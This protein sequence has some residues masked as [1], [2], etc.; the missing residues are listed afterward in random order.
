MDNKTD[1]LLSSLPVIS[2]GLAVVG[3]ISSETSFI[4]SG[5][6]AIVSLWGALAKKKGSDFMQQFIDNKDEISEEVV[7]SEK[8]ISVFLDAFDKNIKESN[9]EKRQLLKNYI[10]NFACGIELNFNEH[11]KLMNVLNLITL[12]EIKILRLWDE[13][14][15]ITV[16]QKSNQKRPFYTIGEIQNVVRSTKDVEKDFFE[17]NDRYNQILLSLG[18][19]G[20]LFVLSQDNFGSG[21]EVKVRNITRFGE[22]FLKFIK[23]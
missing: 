8:F 20:L 3:S 23:Q 11:S 22:I 1:K 16:K 6:V 19:K 12:E 2:Q 9:E 4:T 18:N 13:N 17:N 10:L 7:K 14:G 21:Q 5:V 15:A